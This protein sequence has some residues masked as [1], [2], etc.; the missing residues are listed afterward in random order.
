M[1]REIYRQ[2]ALYISYIAQLDDNKC[3][4]NQIMNELRY[5]DHRKKPALFDEIKKA[6]YR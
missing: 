4:F 1:G 6:I 5:S 2:S 3:L